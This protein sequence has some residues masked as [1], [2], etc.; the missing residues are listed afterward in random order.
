LQPAA[1]PDGVF[2]TA[3]G[4]TEFFM[5]S[6]DFNATGDNRIAVWAMINT[7][8]L[9]STTTTPCAGDI[10]FT[11]VPPILKVPNYFDPPPATQ[12][13]GS[14]PY[15]SS[16]SQSEEQID[17]DDDRVQ[18][19]V[20][21]D[22][23]LYAGLTSEIRVHSAVH[24]GIEYF[25]VKPSF[26]TQLQHGQKVL[27]FH[28]TLVRNGFLAHSGDDLYYPSIGV[29]T[30]GRALMV[31]TLS[32]PTLFPSAAYFPL[33]MGGT[34]QIHMLK[35]GAGPDDGFSGYPIIANTT[36]ARWGDYSAAV[37]QGVDVWMATE[38]IP[39]VCTAT[40]YESD[41]LCGMTRA[42]EA[43][44]GTWISEYIPPS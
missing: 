34:L 10:G 5:D 4:G 31:F 1:P 19:L 17:T 26:F 29:T 27:L 43:N 23:K 15:G 28:V 30:K 42:P 18:Q 36:I 35:A 2:D 44:W 38:Y 37:A 6:L 3:N 22:G 16:L 40:V 25:E 7:C 24:S 32:G 8:A 11:D 39:S 41:P 21:A 9:P 20:Y 12:E 13:A 14:F 33:A